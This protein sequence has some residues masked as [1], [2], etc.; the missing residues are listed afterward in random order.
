MI[1]ININLAA[2][3]VVFIVFVNVY[4]K[5]FGSNLTNCVIEFKTSYLMDSDRRLKP[6]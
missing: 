5:H 4:T 3:A 6:K 2:V 1:N